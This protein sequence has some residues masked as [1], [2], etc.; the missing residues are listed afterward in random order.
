MDSALQR[1]PGDEEGTRE[2]G[3]EMWI[4]IRGGNE[5]LSGVL[6]NSLPVLHL[7][8]YFH[9]FIASACYFQLPTNLI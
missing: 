2:V 5:C 1:Q 7:S 4:D 8:F 6:T 9:I 3:K